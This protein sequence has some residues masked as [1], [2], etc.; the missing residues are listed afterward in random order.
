MR[1][2]GFLLLLSTSAYAQTPP[3]TDALRGAMQV[4]NQHQNTQLPIPGIHPPTFQPGW[5]HCSVI[6]EALQK[7]NAENLSNETMQA[8]KNLADQLK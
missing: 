3:S 2:I 6:L 5:E 1:I 7:R 8:I 4:C